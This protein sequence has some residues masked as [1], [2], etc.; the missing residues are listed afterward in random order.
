MEQPRMRASRLLTPVALAVAA[1]ALT[2]AA[3]TGQTNPA[4]VTL[5]GR[6]VLPAD[7]F[8]SG[9]ATGARIDPAINNGR[10]APFG[11]H[12]VQGV[13]GLLSNGDGTF[14]ALS[15]NGYGNKANSADYHLRV[16]TV[17]PNWRTS[18]G[19]DGGVEVLG[20]FELRDPDRLVPF[21][22]VNQ[23]DP[24]RILTGSDFDLESFRRAPDGTFWFGEEFGPYLIQTDATGK[25]LRA[26]IP[27]PVPPT[28]EFAFAAPAT[29]VRSP[30]HPA[31]AALADQPARVAA[32]NLASSR[33]FEGMALSADGTRLYPLLEGAVKG[34]PDP[35]RLVVSEF[36]LGRAAYT[37]RVWY[38]RMEFDNHAIGDMTAIND[39]QFLVIE[40]DN[41]EG[42]QARFKRVYLIDTAEVDRGY[43]RK[44]EVVDL[45]RIL[46]PAGLAPAEAGAVGLG[47][48]FAMPFVTIESVLMLD[49]STMVIVNDN[50]YPFS[51][52]RRPM[53]PDDSEFI[54]LRLPA[55]LTVT[56]YR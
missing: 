42:A 6:A 14:L 23:N 53:T 47:G 45:M 37:G 28:P 33:G 56:A 18:A 5:T 34:D 7:T 20:F 49:P 16:Y 1:V 55:P 27:L 41:N 11:S 8:A 9:P 52:G 38:Y 3:A 36:D 40:R 39:T 44:T 32:A 13:S 4:Q 50:N 51:A 31:F 29:E 35:R 21:P 17:R 12:P 54:Q 24:A 46:D 10:M 25:L 48:P 22:I 19:G 30:D 43:A 26:P 15:D 2:V